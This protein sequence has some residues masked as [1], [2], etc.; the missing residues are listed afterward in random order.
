MAEHFDGGR[1]RP[2]GA[3]DPRAVLRRR[4]AA[5]GRPRPRPERR[6]RRRERDRVARR[7]L[8]RR[9]P[10]RGRRRRARHDRRPR[11]DAD[12]L[13]PGARRGRRR[14]PAARPPAVE[15][16]SAGGHGDGLLRAARRRT[17]R[18]RRRAEARLPAA[19]ARAAP[20]RERR[21]PRPPRHAS[22]RSPSPTR[23]SATPSGAGVRHVRPGRPARAGRAAAGR[24]LRRRGLGD[25][26]DAFFGGSPFG[27]AGQ[28]AA[29]HRGEDVE[30][31]AR[32]RA[33][34]RPSS[35]SSA[36]V[37][38]RGP[39]TCDDL[40]GQRRRARHERRRAA[41]TAAG[42]GQVRRV[43]QSILGQVV[44]TSPCPRCRGVGRDRSSR[45]ARHCRGEGRRVEE[46]TRHRRGPAGRRRRH[47]A[48]HHR[49]R[50]GAASAGGIPGD[51]Y[52]HLRVAPAR[53]LPALRDRTS[54]PTLHVAL[55][56]GGPRRRAR[57]SRPSTGTRRSP[58]RPGTQSGK[59]VRLRG[60]GV[61]HVRG[62]G[63]GR[64]A[65]PDRRRHPD[66]P[67]QGAG[68]PAPRARRAA[69]RE[70]RERGRAASS[71]DP[72]EPRLTEAGGEPASRDRELL[73][74]A[75]ALV[76][77]EDLDAPAADEDDPPPARRA[78][79]PRRGRVVAA[80]GRGSWRPCAVASRRRGRA[81]RAR[82]RPA[83]GPTL[84]RTIAVPGRAARRREAPAGPALTVGF[85]LQKGDRAEWTVQKLTE[86][87]VDVIVPF[88]PSA[89]S[90]ASTPAEARRRGERLR[91]VAREAAMQSA[92]R[93][94][95]RSPTRSARRRSRARAPP[96][97]ARR[98]AVP[99]RAR[100]RAA[101]GR[102]RPRP[103]R[104]RGRLVAR[105][106]ALG[107]ALVGLG[108]GVL[109][110]ETAAIVAGVLLARAA[111]AGGSAESARRGPWLRCAVG[112]PAS[113]P[114]GHRT[115]GAD[116]RHDVRYP[117]RVSGLPTPRS[118]A[119][120]FARSAGRSGSRCRRSRPRSGQEFKA[121]VL[122]A[123]ER[124]E[125]AISVPR[126]QRLAEL[127]DVPV[128]QLLPEPTARRREPR[129]RASRP[130]ARARRARSPST[131]PAERRP[132][133]PSA[134]ALQRFVA[135]IQVERQDFNGQVLTIR[136]RRPAG[137]RRDVRAERRRDRS[138]AL[139]ELG[140]LYALSGATAGRRAGRAG[141]ASTSTSRSARG[142]ATT[143]PS[144]PGPT[145]APRRRLRRRVP[146]PRSP[147]LE[148]AGRSRRPTPSTSAVGR[149]RCS[150]PSG[151][152]A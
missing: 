74:R 63:R 118:S 105:E 131:S 135:T 5:P 116:V 120:G 103:R 7:V 13:L 68:A 100:W 110:A 49:R 41:P 45:R 128:D 35:A 129:A 83:P 112:Y 60:R 1:H 145:A 85:A 98:A 19:R 113:Q 67:H 132:R 119:S 95:P 141:S 6:D 64:P 94:C 69:R 81:G 27:G 75:E 28:Q 144:P 20:R 143:A 111:G 25:L 106:L 148:H 134:A 16:L 97:L 133:A 40:R 126:L 139:D 54:S 29:P 62:R 77:V 124:G 140:L 89:P 59:V 9:R 18:L 127:Y 46:R 142:G 91:R 104:A 138:T 70:R 56:P 125:R 76:F 53:A 72:L 66:R 152:V 80:D 101:P 51:L 115:T 4:L 33:S 24:H 73:R 17:G 65:R 52:V 151:L 31:V 3:L 86:L 122:G 30:V 36:P 79:S 26:F 147:R 10:L 39:V 109:R 43:R 14:Q 92:G 130:R 34:R 21:R 78:A 22:R 146:R 12:E 58:S 88:S 82:A 136:A 8:A 55:D 38:F 96:R 121:S 117:K 44:T 42:T 123:Y 48:A 149:R 47:D 87:G 15:R 90:S 32:P 137:H 71:P 37:A 61:P 102:R 57:R 108:P 107:R 93:G 84:A 150:P 99:R 50:R 11:P 114:V 2:G 23:P